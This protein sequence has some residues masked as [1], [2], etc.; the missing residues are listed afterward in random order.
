[1][2]R[3]AGAPMPAG[4]RGALR[5]RRHPAAAV[6][7]PHCQAGTGMPCMVR[8]RDVQLLEPHPQRVSAWAQQQAACPVCGVSA[9][10]RCRDSETRERF[11]V[12]AGRYVA[13]GVAL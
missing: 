6:Q 2:R 1:M 3:R 13:A 8:S 9:G 5:S 4:L 7:C 12:H 11:T 10:A